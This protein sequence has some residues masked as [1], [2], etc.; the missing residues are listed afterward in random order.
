MSMISMGFYRTEITELDLK[1]A[2]LRKN[3]PAIRGLPLRKI[4]LSAKDPNRQIP[5]LKTC[6]TLE[7]V[8]LPKNHQ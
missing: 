7:E 3:I 1:E 8:Y 4:T 2:N 5:Y 6:K